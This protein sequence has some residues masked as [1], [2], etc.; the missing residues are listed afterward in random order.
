MNR[1]TT[2]LVYIYLSSMIISQTIEH[3]EHSYEGSD[4]Q[5]NL[6]MA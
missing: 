1:H 5:N 6:V 4:S 3:I 2:C